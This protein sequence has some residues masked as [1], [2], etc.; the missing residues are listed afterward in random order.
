[1]NYK[2]Y[3]IHQFGLKE[4]LKPTVDPSS[5]DP[6]ELKK[7]IKDEMEHTNDP[8]LA[9][10]I[11]LHHLAKRPKYYSELEKCNIDEFNQMQS[12]LSPTVKSPQILAISVKGS[13][14]GGLPSGTN[15]QDTAIAPKGAGVNTSSKAALGGLEP[16]SVNTS[17][18]V[19]VNK[20]PHN[21]AIDSANP[22]SD[23]EGKDNDFNH[24]L[25]MQ[26]KDEKSAQALTGTT[27]DP[28]SMMGDMPHP[29]E[30]EIT[31]DEEMDS[32][33]ETK[34]KKIT[35]TDK[36]KEELDIFRNQ[37]NSSDVGKEIQKQFGYNAGDSDDKNKDDVNET[38]IRHKRLL[39]Q[40]LNLKENKTNECS[41]C[42]CGKPN[43][44]HFKKTKKITES[45][46]HRLKEHFEAKGMLNEGDLKLFEKVNYL[47][48][49]L[50]IEKN[51]NG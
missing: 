43:T 1:M 23:V 41:P 49:K 24:P 17:N 3:F 40:K 28:E 31:S 20:T 4:Q 10:K 14:S 25:Q 51:K 42:K 19:I 44:L 11:A 9:K 15:M 35:W 5:V 37:R 38:F 22:I 2:S 47:L 46:L 21:N 50:Y 27:N 34:R 18:S 13:P 36:E 6:E 39:R 12:L 7:G 30:F 33:N 29:E 8:A 32:L 48:E 26:N 45:Q 16:V